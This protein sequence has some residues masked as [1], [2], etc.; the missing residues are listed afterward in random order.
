MQVMRGSR[1]AV[2]ALA[3]AAAG[4]GGSGGGKKKRLAA[5]GAAPAAATATAPA[6]TGPTRATSAQGART[7]IVIKTRFVDFDGTV[8]AGSHIGDT[9]F[10]AG[11]TLHHQ[12]GS[13]E[14][15]FPAINVFTCGD[16]R[17]KIGFGPGPDQMNNR[18]QT[19][20]WKV[21]EGSGNFAGVTGSG[22]MKVEFPHVGAS[23]G[24]ETFTGAVVLP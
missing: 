6:T 14:I 10:C 16:S 21:L 9:P 19:S 4:L 2:T 17:L 8:V 24:E 15:G 18:I 13:P 23:S 11:G 12:I 20:G 22:R 1:S 7:S 3:L 5:F